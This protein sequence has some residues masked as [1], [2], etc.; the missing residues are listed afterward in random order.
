MYSIILTLSVSSA[1]VDVQGVLMDRLR[2]SGCTGKTATVQ[3]S[4]GCT[5]AARTFGTPVR[6]ALVN[7]P[8]PVRTLFGT[9]AA[10]RP[11][12]SR[13]PAVTGCTGGTASFKTVTKTTTTYRGVVAPVPTV[14][15]PPTPT[16][17]GLIFNRDRVGPIMRVA[18]RNKINSGTLTPAQEGM[19][20]RILTER[21]IAD[22]ADTAAHERFGKVMK[23]GK[24]QGPIWDSFS[25]WVV[26]NLPA[27][28]DALLKVLMDL[29]TNGTKSPY[30]GQYG[31]LVS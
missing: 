29:L 13:L 8:T 11:L 26:Q 24:V 15:S 12:T 2:G 25:A 9:I 22:M 3:A 16:V 28:L 27:I 5:G 7:R 10:S 23:T 1:P 20:R 30:W 18:I 6:N 21:H 14:G 19:A 17:G 31:N 4:S